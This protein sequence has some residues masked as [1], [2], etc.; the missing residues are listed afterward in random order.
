MHYSSGLKARMIQRMSGGD[1][2][3]A[4]KLSREVGISQNTLSRWLREAL[5]EKNVK[6]NGHLAQRGSVR[7][8]DFPA[9]EKFRLVMEL[10]TLVL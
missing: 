8:N 1:L 10:A 5:E 3:S 4:N 6:R 9:A 2:L 7:P